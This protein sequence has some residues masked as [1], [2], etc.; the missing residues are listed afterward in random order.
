M[1]INHKVCLFTT[2]IAIEMRKSGNYFEGIKLFK[3]ALKHNQLA[4]CTKQNAKIYNGISA[5]YYEL[6]FHNKTNTNY[7]DSSF[8]Y[9][10]KALT[11][12]KSIDDT[13]LNASIL[14][15]LGGINIHKENFE[16][17]KNYLLSADSINTDIETGLAIN[18]NLAYTY[19]SMGNYQIALALAKN[20]YIN[21]ANNNKAVF[22]GISL[23]NIIRI[24][25]AMGD[26]SA[27]IHTK[28]K[29]HEINSHRDAYIQELMMKH[30]ALSYAQ[31]QDRKTITGL[32]ND[33]LLLVKYSRLLIAVSIILLLI[34]IALLFI[35]LQKKR[36][37]QKENE[38]LISKE[39][40]NQLKIKNAELLLQKKE[41][42][43]KILKTDLEIK[44]TALASKLLSLSQIHEFLSKIRH[45]FDAKKASI[46]DPETI[47]FLEEISLYITNQQNNYHLE[48]F[49]LLYASGN[50]NFIQKLI[51]IHPDLSVNEKKLCYLI[52][53][54]LTTKD[55][56]NLLHKSYRSVEMARHRLRNKLN[57]ERT[58]K[59]FDYLT[60]FSDNHLT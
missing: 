59:L 24:Y 21:S 6:Y 48:E 57:L 26:S 52:I 42:E 18:N 8:L 10:N 53:I 29:L 31:K 5:I 28:E 25:Y 55:I 37:R 20:C 56:S 51:K 4:P 3:D 35:M 13:T 2:K 60:K 50:S 14:N 12:N 58:D 19:Y 49:E 33:H 44:K 7:L 32:S 39:L 9:A 1:G 36:I 16:I 34:A 43:E 11:I 30:L 27:A 23:E 47:A 46:K 54:N 41:D 17:A 40:T 15:I 22:C 45:K 38:L